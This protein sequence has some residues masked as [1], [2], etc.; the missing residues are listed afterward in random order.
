LCLN[1]KKP[2]LRN[3]VMLKK[4]QAKEKIREAAAQCFSR[5]GLDKTTLEDIG[6]AVGLNKASLYYYYKNKEAIFIEVVLRESE[7]F[8]SALQEKSMQ[9]KGA[10]NRVQHYLA[11][12]IIY[13]RY[14]LNLHQVSIEVEPVF[15]DLYRSVMEREIAFIRQLLQEG[16][17]SGELVKIDAGKVANTFITLSD[18]LKHKALLTA[19]V[20]NAA[21]ADYSSITSD[22]KYM[23]SLIFNGLKK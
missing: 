16:V 2:V 18:S 5:Y 19:G 8:I 12:R 6:R 14:V 15:H 10:E 11:E 9:K 22:L 13:Y 21:D 4:E 17:K 20:E 1:E 23:V 3:S 7:Q